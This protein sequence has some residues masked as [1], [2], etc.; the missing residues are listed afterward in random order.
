MPSS[1]VATRLLIQHY[2]TPGGASQLPHDAARTLARPAPQ[3]PVG[4]C[5]Y[6]PR[7]PVLRTRVPV[8]RTRV[9]VLRA[10]VPVLRTRIELLPLHKPLHEPV[11]VPRSSDAFEVLL[12]RAELHQDIPHL[13]ARASCHILAPP[14]LEPSD[15]D[16]SRCRGISILVNS[17][18]RCWNGGRLHKL[19]ERPHSDTLDLARL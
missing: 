14:S 4:V 8:L 13:E 12:S 3:P 10:L 19:A 2:S 16:Q 18:K 9:P 17:A 6:Q 7:V 1:R 11:R 5:R 15:L